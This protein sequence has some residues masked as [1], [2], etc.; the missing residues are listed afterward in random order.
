MVLPLTLLKCVRIGEKADCTHAIHIV[1]L[2]RNPLRI[3]RRRRPRPRRRLPQPQPSPCLS[4][5]P[6]SLQH[7]SSR[8]VFLFALSSHHQYSSFL[9]ISLQYIY[10]AAKVY[11]SFLT[12]LEERTVETTLVIFSS[13]TVKRKGKETLDS[14]RI[15]T[16]PGQ[17]TGRS[18]LFVCLLAVVGVLG[19]IL[20]VY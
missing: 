12:S 20:F 14:T 13:V 3:R 15:A 9:P 6:P 4:P 16:C 17:V 11:Q 10:S 5:N 8:S 1:I 19:G 7:Q 2:L 18:C